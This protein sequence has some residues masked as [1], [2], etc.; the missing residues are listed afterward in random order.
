MV[1]VSD[2]NHLLPQR[3]CIVTINVYSR[4]EFLYIIVLNE[5]P[6]YIAQQNNEHCEED[7]I[8][9]GYTT[10]SGAATVGYENNLHLRPNKANNLKWFLWV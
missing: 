4:P 7:N 1:S 6:V 9:M 8:S 5:I 3:E 2:K 10:V